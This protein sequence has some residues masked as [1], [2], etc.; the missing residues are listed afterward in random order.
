MFNAKIKSRS[1]VIPD[2][3]KLVSVKSASFLQTSL[4]GE[5]RNKSV[6]GFALMKWPLAHLDGGNGSYLHG[7]S[8][9]S[10]CLCLKCCY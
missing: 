7:G 5:R 8:S 4:S 2:G 10:V 9:L 1:G 6:S 3:V